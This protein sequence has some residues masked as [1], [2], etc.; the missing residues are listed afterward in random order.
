MNFHIWIMRKIFDLSL[1]CAWI[2]Y[3]KSNISIFEL[4]IAYD[5]S[6]MAL[7]RKAKQ[8]ISLTERLMQFK[9]S[10]R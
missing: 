10:E 8:R 9:I 2:E 6:A 3:E 1:R 7:E 4:F 5:R